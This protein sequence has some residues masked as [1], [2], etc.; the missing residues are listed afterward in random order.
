MVKIISMTYNK[1]FDILLTIFPYEI[2]FKILITHKG[3]RHPI[4]KLLEPQF[5]F[6]N[7]LRSEEDEFKE[8]TILSIGRYSPFSHHTKMSNIKDILETH[9]RRMS[10]HI[11]YFRLRINPDFRHYIYS[12]SREEELIWIENCWRSQCWKNHIE[13]FI[14]FDYIPPNQIFRP[15]HEKVGAKRMIVKQIKQILKINKIKGYSKLR[16]KELI[17]LYFSF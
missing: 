4:I 9:E 1:I 13:Y 14:N 17:K 8:R 10:C 12:Q 6:Y 7:R 11:A 15:L 2:V 5:E 3:L 16:R